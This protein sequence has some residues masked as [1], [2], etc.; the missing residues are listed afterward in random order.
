MRERQSN[1]ARPRRVLRGFLQQFK[2]LSVNFTSSHPCHSIVSMGVFEKNVK[3]LEQHHPNLVAL[4]AE[5]IP[6]DHITIARA[7]SGA[8]RLFV[9]ADSGEEVALHDQGDPVQVAE[10]TAEQMA[11]RLKG[12]LVVLGFELGYFAK[13]LIRR[14]PGNCALVVYEADPGIFLTALKEVDLTD[15]LTSPQVGVV[16]GPKANLR[17]QCTQFVSQMGGPMQVMVYDPAFRLAPDVYGE[18]TERDLARIPSIVTAMR[19][20]VGR[21][22]ARVIECVFENIPHVVLAEGVS[23]LKGLFMG[24]PA[25][26][27]AAGPSLGKNVYHL[28]QAKGRA[29]IIAADTALSYLLVRGIVPDFVVSVDPQEG[30]F[31]KYQG[32]DIPEE[33]ALVFHPSAYHRIVKHF[34]GPKYALDAAMPAY[35]WLQEHWSRKG[36]LDH[37][38]MC[39]AHVGFNLA[40]WMGCGSIVLVGQDLSYTQEG[41]HVKHGGYLTEAEEAKNVA[42]GQVTRNIFGEPVKTNPTYL[43]YKAIFEKKIGEFPG[44][45]LNATEGGLEIEGARLCRLADALVE[46]G[47]KTHID[48]GEILKGV[49]K[50]QPLPDW[51]SLLQEIRH[52][53]RDLSRIERTARHVCRLLEKMKEKRQVSPTVDAELISFGKA[54]EQLTSFIP[55]YTTA[56]GL[57]HWMDIELERQLTEDTDALDRIRDHNAKHDKQIDRGLKYYG[58]LAREAP[59]LREMVLRLLHRLECWRDLESQPKEILPS[60][61]KLEVVQRYVAL[62]LYDQAATHLAHHLDQEDQQSLTLAETLLWVRVPLE[63]HQITLAF[64]RAQSAITRFPDNPELQ[65]LWERANEEWQQWQQKVETAQ[66]ESG[67][68]QDT[69]LEAGDFYQRVGDFARAREHYRQAV[70]EH[71]T[72]PE[73]ARQFFPMAERLVGN[74][75]KARG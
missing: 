13:A 40:Q 57:L 73:E 49:R 54:V 51:E 16:V 21:R 7:E 27:V 6:T 23:H 5:S 63:R 66:A 43:N 61:G 71:W 58:G 39:Q 20:A 37:E 47:E 64:A 45:V 46:C 22:G 59:L 38:T 41:L 68:K 55:R 26:L 25:I 35:Q 53:A 18:K 8:S 1:Q 72:L 44:K 30:T 65:S 50:S 62:E 74:S 33:V 10:G 52:R 19:N 48:V 36:P 69:H 15:V 2:G 28:E 31:K 42:E 12:V 14:M 67:P 34:P 9:Q 29:I 24:V 17:H 32:V 4:L 75:E 3:A 11:G 56:R 70:E 60:A